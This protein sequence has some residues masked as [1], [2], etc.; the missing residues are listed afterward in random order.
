VVSALYTD[1]TQTAF[2]STPV[3]IYLTPSKITLKEDGSV[4][5]TRFEQDYTDARVTV[6][7]SEQDCIANNTYTVSYIVAIQY[8]DEYG[9]LKF[10]TQDADYNQVIGGVTVDII[11]DVGI[12]D[13]D[14][15]VAI[16][17]VRKIGTG[18]SAKEAIG[19]LS[20][21]VLATDTQKP[22]PPINL[23][24]QY[25]YFDTPARVVLTWNPPSTVTF[26][27][28]DYF[29]VYRRLTRNGV[30]IEPNK[31]LNGD[32]PVP[33]VPGDNT[34]DYT[35]LTEIPPLQVN[36]VLT[37][38]VTS[39][40][41]DGESVPSNTVQVI[42][43]KPS[44]PPREFEVSGLIEV[45]TG[46]GSVAMTWI[47][48]LE[49]VGL[50]DEG[51]NH[52]YFTVTVS[53][54]DAYGNTVLLKAENYPYVAGANTAYAEGMN[55]IP[56][57]STGDVL[58]LVN[59]LITFNPNTAVLYDVIIGQ[60]AFAN[61][62]V[63]P[64]PFITDI[65]GIPYNNVWTTETGSNSFNVYS[66]APLTY[67]SVTIVAY[68]YSTS[69]LVRYNPPQPTPVLIP[70]TEYG[71]FAGA[72]CYSYIAPTTPGGIAISIVAA[73]SAGYQQRTL[74]GQLN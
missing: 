20:N 26:I 49:V 14:T 47:Q 59:R 61:T 37:Y 16:Q 9:N 29:Y 52:A 69:E 38:W 62:A 36:D 2:Q 8:V 64:V 44:S 56:N 31:L 53:K 72:L 10:I 25:F 46:E 73:N 19:E 43:I 58:Y 28:V 45:G 21:T 7:F 33:Y 34:Y 5:I 70:I 66:F 35:D 27:N 22:Q 39:V 55:N 40:N 15:Y 12:S 74:T 57:V 17:A 68:E 32:D 65:N 6:K 51:Y 18:A 13:S 24:A 4:F 30:V 48:P 11:S 23:T 63:Y 60:A 54:I 1:G 67:P 41:E 50:T 71:E 3:E 42:V